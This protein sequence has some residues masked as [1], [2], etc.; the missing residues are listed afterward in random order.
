MNNTQEERKSS[1]RTDEDTVA[2]KENVPIGYYVWHIEPRFGDV[3]PCE[4][5]TMPHHSR[6]TTSPSALPGT[7]TRWE[8]WGLP[9]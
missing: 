2:E 7:T 6:T 5:D 9:A 8:T 3:K 1:W 4:I